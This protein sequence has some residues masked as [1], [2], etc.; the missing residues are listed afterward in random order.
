MSSSQPPPQS[1]FHHDDNDGD[2]DTPPSETFAKAKA[3]LDNANDGG[4]SP[5]TA[6][7]EA[8]ALLREL[9]VTVSQCGIFSKNE[10]LEDVATNSLELLGVEFQLGRALLMLPTNINGDHGNDNNHDENKNKVAAN[11]NNQY[12]NNDDKDTMGESPSAMRKK[13]VLLAVEYFH[14]FLK[15]LDDLGEGMLPPDTLKDYHMLLD[16]DDE[17]QEI[18]NTNPL[19][20]SDDDKN[21]HHSNN[22]Q[23]FNR[24]GLS[25]A[26]TRQLK[27]QRYQRKKSTSQTISHLQ[28]LLHR[29]NRLSIEDPNEIMDGYD[30]ES[31]LRN[32][33]I[34]TLRVCA[35]EALEE[36]QS[37]RGEWEMLEMALAMEKRNGGM[38]GGGRD[39]RMGGGLPRP[40]PGDA[41]NNNNNNDK[42]PMTL[43]Q[44]TQNPVTGQLDIRRVPPRSN[45]AFPS[46]TSTSISTLP[47]RQQI[48]DTVFRPH[49]NLPTM[50]LSELAERERAEAIQRGEAQKQAEEQAKFRPRRY[51]QLVRDGM[52][53][54]D[55]LVEASAKL[56]RD[57][58]DWK[59]ENPRGSGNK[60]S[61]RGDRNF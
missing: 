15:R 13:N 23:R 48:A 40:R 58:D 36:M 47:R 3:L 60:M 61:E 25:P 6:I 19:A 24:T 18:N 57:W 22:I 28:S 41:A 37:S 2:I 21:N 33:R 27:I 52:E 38:M 53:D 54:D 9:Q 56:D 34:E 49:W 20:S 43:T 31:L 14:G 5:T 51:D 12:S 30:G 8:I 29:R 59:E 11:D 32:L 42:G 4:T 55:E 10:S 46:A 16:L 7:A 44:I 35:E 17:R 45:E 26:Q 1:K 39:F 50:S